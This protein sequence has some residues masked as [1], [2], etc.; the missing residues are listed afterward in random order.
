MPSPSVES[1]LSRLNAVPHGPSGR[2]FFLLTD[3]DPAAFEAHQT[4]WLAA[5]SP[6]DLPEREAALAAIRAMWREER[7]DRLEVVVLNDLFAAGRIADAAERE[8][9]RALAFKALGTLLRYRARVEREY[10]QAKA[11][12]DALRQRRLDR[13]PAARPSE[14][15]PARRSDEA[16]AAVAAKPVPSEPEPPPLNRHQRRALAAMERQAQRR[17]A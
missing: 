2:N 5:W 17:A 11:A 7:A 14:P 9:A 3:E 8:A 12:L 13:P 1:D 4:M 6:C 15:E 10:R 16:V